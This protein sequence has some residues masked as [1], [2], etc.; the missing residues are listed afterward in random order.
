LPG[1]A[2]SA[3][4]QEARCRQKAGIPPGT[5]VYRYRFHTLVIEE[6]QP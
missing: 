5:P 2:L 6:P 1:E 3:G 4:W